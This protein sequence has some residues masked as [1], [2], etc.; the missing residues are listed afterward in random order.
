MPLRDHF[1]PPLSVRRHWH[2]FHNAWATAMSI[3]LN[4][5][6]PERCFAEPNAQ[7][8]IEIDVATWEQSPDIAGSAPA[9]EPWT[10]P[11]P[12]QTLL[13]PLVGDV[14]EVLVYETKAGPTLIGAIELVSPSNKDWPESRAAFVAT[15]ETLLQQA[16]GLVIVDIV[17]SLSANLH[18]ELMR[19]SG[20]SEST[21]GGLY[22]SAYRPVE[23]DGQ[24]HLEVWH[25]P[26][27]IGQGLPTLPLWLHGLGCLRLD[28]SATY[29]RTC[30]EQRIEGRPPIRSG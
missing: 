24:P 14:V 6:L 27:L 4:A 16:V 22:N 2:S 9:S 12:T 30:R 25:E 21:P 11:A 5:C 3:D 1:H 19:R 17:G 23:R 8:G 29:E 20:G 18:N 15:C 13:F 26:L 28:L 10:P 7:F